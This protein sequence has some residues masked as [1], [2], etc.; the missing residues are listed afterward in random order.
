M[1]EKPL[2]P[3]T[4]TGPWL[5]L[6]KRCTDWRKLFFLGLETWSLF[7]LLGEM[8]LEIFKK[9]L[10]AIFPP[11]THFLIHLISRS[12]LHPALFPHR[13]KLS[14]IFPSAQTRRCS[15][16]SLAPSPSPSLR[17]SEKSGCV[18]FHLRLTHASR[19]VG[20][21]ED[22]F[23]CW[24]ETLVMDAGRV[25]ISALNGNFCQNRLEAWENTK[26]EWFYH[27]KAA[28]VKRL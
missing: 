26:T 24:F 19:C 6:R 18:L 20:F 4:L 14:L 22:V 16:F 7:W 15:S 13:I 27:Q 8:L 1:N 28:D 10:K 25:G 21:H 5:T 3:S 2:G 12:A 9:V 17:I 23:E 11:K